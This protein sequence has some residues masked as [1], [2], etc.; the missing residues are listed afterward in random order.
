MVSAVPLMY[1]IHVHVVT[2]VVGVELALISVVLV[3]L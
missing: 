3:G 1:D 2:V